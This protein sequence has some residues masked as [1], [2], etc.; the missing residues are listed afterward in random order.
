MP[1]ST[2]TEYSI[3]PLKTKTPERPRARRG[4]R[5]QTPS[6]PAPEQLLEILRRHS[7]Q[8]HIFVPVILVETGRNTEP[9]QADYPRR[10]AQDRTVPYPPQR[11]QREA[12]PFVHPGVRPLP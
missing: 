10:S 5:F 4:P 11:P 8:L 7:A 12:Q 2:V 3:L 9:R 1:R 6:R